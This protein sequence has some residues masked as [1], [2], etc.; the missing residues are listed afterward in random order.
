MNATYAELARGY[1]REAGVDHKVELVVAPA[2][3]TLA[4]LLARPGE[5]GTYDFAFVDADKTGYDT[6]YEL[7]LRLLRTGGIVAFDNTLQ[8]GSVVD[9]EVDRAVAGDVEPGY[10]RG[11]AEGTEAIRRLNDKLA[12]DKRVRA[13]QL[14][15]GDGYTM[16]TKL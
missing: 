13:V 7:C 10:P 2:A 14:N 5:E 12:A 6:Y 8:R 16:V 4:G 9:K 3:D 11:R 15:I 1:W